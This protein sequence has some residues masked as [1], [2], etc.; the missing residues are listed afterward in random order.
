[1]PSL[2]SYDNFAG[3][4]H[5]LWSDWYLPA[6]MPALEHLFFSRI[7]SGAAVLDVC[8][9]SGHVTR[10]LTRRDYQVT[11][12]DVSEDLLSIS[13]NEMPQV[14]W[15]RHDVRFMRLP[16]I[17]D[18]AISTFDSLNHILTRS[19]LEE[20]FRNVHRTLKPGGLFVFDMNLQE[21]FCADMQAWTANVGDDD[22]SL[23]RGFFDHATK[24]ARTE[25][26][27][28]RREADAWIRTDTSIE[29]RCYSQT[30]IVSALSRAGFT[31]IETVPAS[32]AGMEP[33]VGFGRIFVSAS[34]LTTT[35]S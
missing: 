4:Y 13:R 1:M 6:A 9:G 8:C 33:A 10:E 5:R 29:E 21:A 24:I 27:W 17:Y 28:L 35:T 18:A 34:V 31:A 19:D 26:V 15:Q 32:E 3:L 25:I 7:P 22:V 12:V 16:R 14:D 2:S 11:G 20:V 23:I 30:E